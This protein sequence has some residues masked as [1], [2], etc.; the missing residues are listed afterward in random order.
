VLFGLF[1]YRASSDKEYN[2]IYATSYP[3]A[4]IDLFQVA[5]QSSKHSTRRY[6]QPIL[7]HPKATL[8]SQAVRRLSNTRRS[9]LR[10]TGPTLAYSNA[11]PPSWTPWTRSHSRRQRRNVVNRPLDI[12]TWR[13]S[14]HSRRLLIGEL[15]LPSICS[16]SMYVLYSISRSSVIWGQCANGRFSYRGNQRRMLWIS[17][18]MSSSMRTCARLI[19]R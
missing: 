11:T 4:C 9:L 2:T 15:D 12:W 14:Q 7:N 6:H 16:V 19:S 18:W 10:T 5:E 3:C 13:G 17:G 8:V 1:R